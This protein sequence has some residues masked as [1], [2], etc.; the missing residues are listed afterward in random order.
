M[1]NSKK[2]IIVHIVHIISWMKNP[3]SSMEIKELGC[4]YNS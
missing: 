3:F 1:N 2:V 4:F